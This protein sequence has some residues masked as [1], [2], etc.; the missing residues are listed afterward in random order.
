[1]RAWR[2][3]LSS[4]LLA[5]IPLLATAARAEVAE[6]IWTALKERQVVVEK[7]DGSE[8]AGK[9]V[10]VEAA[11][12]VVL[13]DSGEPV[14]IEKTSVRLVRARVDSAP[15]PLPPPPPGLMPT[16]PPPP[17][18][19]PPAYANAGEMTYRELELAIKLSPV[20]DLNELLRTRGQ[21]LFQL[22][23]Y[24]REALLASFKEP[25]WSKAIG[26]ALN[27]LVFPGTGSLYQGDKG[28]GFP[29]L[30][31]GL[32][33][34]GLVVGGAA[35]EISHGKG[36]GMAITGLALFGGAYLIGLVRPWLYDGIRYDILRSYLSHP[37]RFGARPTLMPTLIAEPVG[38]AQISGYP[39]TALYGLGVLGRF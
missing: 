11:R 35:T 5:F 2:V 1:M 12:V 32:L 22:D 38:L 19:V 16:T 21:A 37:E 6:A 3:Q 14:V 30:G 26:F 15:N 31:A 28:F 36:F 27:W 17:G 18:S 29:L 13:K 9:L 25:F 33:G 23:V 10:G 7:T 39:R 34:I 24:Q 8:V 4:I 20:V